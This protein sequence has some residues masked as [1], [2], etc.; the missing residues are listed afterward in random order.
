MSEFG[1]EAFAVYDIADV[2]ALSYPAVAGVC[3]NVEMKCFAFDFN[4]YGFSLYLIANACRLKMGAF[5]EASDSGIG[6]CEM[7]SYSKHG[8]VFHQSD[9][10]R[11]GKHGEITTPYR[12]CCQVLDHVGI[13]AVAQTFF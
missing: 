2:M 6:L 9:H 7:R 12:F 4:E 13:A 11:S 10:G 5:H 3:G 8:C 1:E